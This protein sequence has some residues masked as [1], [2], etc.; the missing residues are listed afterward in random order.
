MQ[1]TIRKQ[2]STE[3][4]TLNDPYESNGSLNLLPTSTL[5][6]AVFFLSLLNE[7]QYTI[8][9]LYSAERKHT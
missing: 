1:Y 3:R 8:R 5:S 2:C 7:M 4:K 9:Q 6:N